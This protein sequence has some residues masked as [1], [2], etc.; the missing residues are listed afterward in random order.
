VDGLLLDSDHPRAA[1]D[2]ETKM[3]VQRDFAESLYQLSLF[4][5]GRD[6]L[7]TDQE[8]TLKAFNG[9][10]IPIH[11]AVVPA[12]EALSEQ[13]L[14]QE[15]KDCA[16]G[17]LVALGVRQLEHAAADDE[18]GPGHVMLSYQVGAVSSCT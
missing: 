11:Q 9:D 13:A 2:L 15:A 10:L 8:L 16:D 17:A 1:S 12:L 3:A 6:A 14:S 7:L 5:E 18:E 4:P